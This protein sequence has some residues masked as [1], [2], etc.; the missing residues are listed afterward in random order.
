VRFPEVLALRQDIQALRGLAVLLVVAFHVAPSAAPAG[1]LGVDVFFVISGYLL[2]GQVI[3]ARARG[4]FSYRT[5]L[6]RRFV[7]LAVPAAPVY[8]VVAIA[9]LVLLTADEKAALWAQLAGAITF[10]SDVVLWSQGGY[11]DQDAATKPLLHTWALST[12]FQAAVVFPLIVGAWTHWRPGVAAVAVAGFVAFALLARHA[13]DAAYF[14][15]PFRLWEFAVG[16]LVAGVSS[17]G[18]APAARRWAMPGVVGAVAGVACTAG[19]GLQPEATIFVCIAVAMALVLRA[20]TSPV[21]RPFAALGAISYPLYLIH[22]PALAFA[23]SLYLGVDPPVVV[24]AAIVVV[25]IVLAYALHRA[26]EVRRPIDARHGMAAA[27]VAALLAGGVPGSADASPGTDWR[28]ERRPNTGLGSQC[29][30]DGP[31]EPRSD[32]MTTSA[33]QIL[34]WGDSVAM[35]WVE[36]LVRADTGHL[37]I[38]QATMSTC[39]P[40]LGI[41]PVYSGALGDQWARR[42]LAFND[43]VLSWLQRETGIRHVLLSSIFAY[44]VERGQ[45]LLT[46]QGR[47]PQTVD[48][49]HAALMKTVNAIR[50]AG[51]SVTVVGPAPVADFDVGACLERVASGL[52]IAGRRT[53]DIDQRDHERTAAAV[54]ELLRRVES[55]RVSVVRPTA[56]LCDGRVCRTEL[57][58]QAL[59]RD[60][61]HISYTGSVALVARLGLLRKVTTRD[62]RTSA[63][64]SAAN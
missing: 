37:G 61:T 20:E 47:A 33:P 63:Q 51:K 22:W 42:C 58:G 16:A 41:S 13:P 30:F 1:F 49:A 52:P 9:G 40:M 11:F 35:Q 50:A 7:R 5:T 55:S 43:A 23:R 31:F 56:V 38:A 12:V 39:G 44:N 45:Q 2:A 19:P 25:S 14:L 34:V 8:V 10:T 18:A 3:A 15:T 4:S 17:P 26:V 54:L 32:C 57:D 59:Y 60:K 28:E 6:W 62:F 46:R 29:E 21:W 27:M 24:V 53:C 64:R 48:A 36:G